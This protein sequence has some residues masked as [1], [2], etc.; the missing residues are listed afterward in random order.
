MNHDASR[1]FTASVLL[2]VVVAACSSAGPVTTPAPVASPAQTAAPA[3]PPAIP[4]TPSAP[5]STAPPSVAPPSDAPPAAAFVWA[6]T[7]P[8][9]DMIPTGIVQGPKGHL[10]VA[11]PY[12]H[13]FAIFKP[14]GS[15]VEFWGTPG[16]GN[17]QL[18]LTRRNGDGYGAVA[19]APDGSFYVLDV[20]NHRVQKFDA[21]RKFVKAWGSLGSGPGQYL[22]PVGIAV[23]PD[24]RVHVLD[25]ER[26]VVET[27]DANGTVLGS[28]GAYV[29]GVQAFDGSNALALDANGNFY[30]STASP[31]EV[32]RFDPDGKP[33][34]TYGAPG[35]GPGE[36]H[37]QAG[38][39]SVDGAGRLFVTQGPQRGDQPAVLVFGPD[40]GY[41]T[42]WG[43]VGSSD[44]QVAFPTGV[45]VD[46][47]GD[48]Y[49]GD[50]SSMPDAGPPGRVQKFH[51]PSFAP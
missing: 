33:T 47:A 20:G 7:S 8:A 6:A 10:W 21:K 49:V 19:F 3:T 42:G 39:M 12:S 29:G 14:D 44:G 50:R 30:V 16:D 24:G 15:F 37:E 43:P 9:G 36:F 28:F 35:S 1:R 5:A 40:G 2:G 11:D 18:K 34:M 31:N 38:L 46:A 22:D 23:G 51:G 45:L 32:Q 4:A 13:R 25:D 48:V 17:G 27:Y 26:G 41:L